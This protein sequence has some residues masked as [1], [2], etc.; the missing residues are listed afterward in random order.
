MLI[1]T[2]REMVNNYCTYGTERKIMARKCKLKEKQLQD[3]IKQ[4]AWLLMGSIVQ[5]SLTEVTK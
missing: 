4:Q 1:V 5:F 3:K 2:A